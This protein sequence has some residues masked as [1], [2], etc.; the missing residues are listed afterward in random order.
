MINLDVLL[1]VGS[2]D[3]GSWGYVCK[4]RMKTV[5]VVDEQDTQHI[6]HGDINVQAL[7]GQLL[8]NWT[9]T[10]LR[11]RMIN[12]MM[13]TAGTGEDRQAVIWMDVKRQF[14]VPGSRLGNGS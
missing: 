9:T 12:M 5:I 1:I 2:T 3:T 13:I 11:R 4:R 6:R 7:Y 8:C 14:M 10:M